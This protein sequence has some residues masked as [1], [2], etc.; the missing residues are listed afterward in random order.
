MPLETVLAVIGAALIFAIVI[1]ALF[2]PWI[3]PYGENASVG[4]A[5]EPWSAVHVFGT[6]SIGRDILSRM[7]Y[8]GRNT[9]GLA[10]AATCLA[11]FIGSALGTAAAV[12]GGWVDLVLG[13]LN[14]L[15]MAIPQL[16][17]ALLILT[18][19][20]S[21]AYTL[22]AVIGVLES[23]RVFRLARSLSVSIV[24][25]DF[26]EVAKL[27]GESLGWIVFREVV[28]VSFPNLLA[29]FGLRFSF[30]ILF[31]SSLSFLGLGLQPPTADWGALVR[32]N[33]SLIAF[34][35]VTPLLPAG[36]IALLTVAVNLVVDWYL[37]KIRR[38]SAL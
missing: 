21:S 3:A 13:R 5:Y 23:T 32:E 14:D 28:P 7:I 1:T 25:Q 35:D 2:A 30:T 17:F 26:V 22:I 27:R 9:I 4:G 33:A 31:V 37:A 6:D 12:L 20:G 8:G 38:R 18:V 24:H 19:V 29:E 15:L 10:F 11:F 36:A 34:G 16:I